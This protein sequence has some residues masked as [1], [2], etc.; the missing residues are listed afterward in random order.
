MKKLCVGFFLLVYGNVSLVYGSV[1]LGT[2]PLL[3]FASTGHLLYI[4][5]KTNHIYREA[6]I[7][8]LTEGFSLISNCLDSSCKSGVLSELR[9]GSYSSVYVSGTG[10]FSYSIT[11]AGGATPGLT[12]QKSTATVGDLEPLPT[13]YVA[14]S[15]YSSSSV[16]FCSIDTTTDYGNLVS[17]CTTESSSVNSTAN[18]SY[19][20]G[21]VYN[22]LLNTLYVTNQG[23]GGWVSVC[24][25]S[26]TIDSMN[27]S[28]YTDNAFSVP[29]G[30]ALNA[31][32]DTL[33]ISNGN[34]YVDTVAIC[35]VD[36]TSGLIISPC[37]SASVGIYGLQGIAYN[38]L[39]STLYVA[40]D[41]GYGN[42]VSQCSVSGVTLGCTVLGTPSI[43]GATGLALN[44]GA[45][46]LYASNFTG[47]SVS[48]CQ[49]TSG[50]VDTSSCNATGSSYYD[51]PAGIDL[52]NG[53]STFAYVANWSNNAV[54]I[55][56]VTS[57]LPP[58][59][60]TCT[61]SFTDS[62]SNPNGIA[63]MD[64]TS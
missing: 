13:P 1:S 45:T 8:I 33:Y 60:P 4:T 32:G 15:N 39:A 51:N 40:S 53:T 62:F 49:V 20:A 52:F 21:L 34:S 5:A 36:T 63:V 22:P 2:H 48:A 12:T 46:I 57:S 35:S 27:C 31:A 25:F 61:S 41:F 29:S 47:D 59:P 23:E 56:T 38:N 6:K 54:S 37:V 26:G 44:P 28:K 17:P 30:A 55:C 10:T 24:T 3:S 42:V 18:F 19:P 58:S 50:V 11:L 14:V 16:T 9:N 43:D 64:V 7:Q